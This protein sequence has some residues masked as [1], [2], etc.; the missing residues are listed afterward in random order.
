MGLQI[1]GNPGVVK[2]VERRAA[3]EFQLELLHRC[4]VKF[5][6][7]CPFRKLQWFGAVWTGA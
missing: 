3:Q 2:G 4:F 6:S 5:I 7:L 1:R